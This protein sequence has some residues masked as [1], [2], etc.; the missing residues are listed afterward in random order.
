MQTT[1]TN[2]MATEMMRSALKKAKMRLKLCSISDEVAQQ[3][4]QLSSGDPIDTQAAQKLLS[5]QEDRLLRACETDSHIAL[6]ESFDW[7]YHEMALELTSQFI[8][9]NNCTT[10]V[11]KMQAEITV[12]AFIRILDYSRK[13]NQAL[14]G[15]TT[16]GKE[17]N[18]RIALLI[19]QVDNATRQFHSAIATLK[20]W[21]MSPVS[22]NINMNNAFVAQNIQK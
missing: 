7:R 4:L 13:L 18:V 1:T 16:A 5:E 12:G 17:W 21:K 10:V 20:H 15:Y 9:E 14:D 6:L 8:I 11:E 19:K 22:L 3:L 2:E